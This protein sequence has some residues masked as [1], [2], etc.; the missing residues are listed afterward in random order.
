[1]S[2]NN[3]AV[4]CNA[5][6]ETKQFDVEMCS[7]QNCKIDAFHNFHFFYLRSFLLCLNDL[8]CK[9]KSVL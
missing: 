2:D 8:L 6:A 3:L 5:V 1:M 7:W 4:T 9:E